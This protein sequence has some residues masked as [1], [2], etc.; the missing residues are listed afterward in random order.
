MSTIPGPFV[1]GGTYGSTERGPRP[2]W[3]P[4]YAPGLEE[5]ELEESGLEESELQGSD[6]E[7]PVP[8]P[9][10]TVDTTEEPAVRPAPPVTAAE[11]AVREEAASQDEPVPE[12]DEEIE[13][14]DY[15]FGAE[16]PGSSEV[17]E[18]AVPETAARGSERSGEPSGELPERPG[19]EPPEDL[20][21]RAQQLLEGPL[22]AELHELMV[23]L[24][25]LPA[26]EAVARAFAAGYRR[27]QIGEER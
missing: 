3:Q 25:G 5:S 1:G 26:S 9:E 7:Q 14:P 13:Y 15:I 18:R 12:E 17:S 22:G 4:P 6:P 11:D 23:R 10:A 21:R 27:G 2:L 16:D 19:L 24:E 20:T 8:G